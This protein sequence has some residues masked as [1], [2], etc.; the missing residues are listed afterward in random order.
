MFWMPNDSLKGNSYNFSCYKQ[1]NKVS[2][3]YLENKL[4]EDKY[5]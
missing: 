3:V 2:L 1:G 4:Q 5:D